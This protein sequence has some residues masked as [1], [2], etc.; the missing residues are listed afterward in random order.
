MTCTAP[1]RT[2][3]AAAA[4]AALPAA[5]APP[6]DAVDLPAVFRS[7][8]S[9]AWVVTTELD[10]RPVGFTAIS[11]ASVSLAPPLVSFNASRTSSSL[12]ALLATRR[13]AVHL[14]AHDQEDVARRFAAPAPQRFPDDGSW[15][16][17]R[18]GLPV[19]RG[20]SARLAGPLVQV[21]EA[22]DSLLLLLQ[23]EAVAATGS[24]PL[25]HHARSYHR[26]VPALPS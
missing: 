11:V 24:A 6:L 12:P 7:V 14:L 22:G 18:D 20:A 26:L 8:A 9:S 23:A 2:T 5:A 1:A 17:G 19:V 10:G 4:P 3:P 15:A 25:V 13:A 21:V 16:W